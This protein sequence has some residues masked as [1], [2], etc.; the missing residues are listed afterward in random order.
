MTESNTVICKHCGREGHQ[1]RNHWNC[2]QHRSRL[3]HQPE[4]NN[5][6][7]SQKV[8]KFC[9]RIGHVRRSN[10]NCG[11]RIGSSN[12][13]SISASVP[14]PIFS[15]QEQSTEPVEQQQQQPSSATEEP[16]VQVTE[17]TICSHC[18]REGHQRR[19]HWNCGANPQNSNMDDTDDADEGTSTTHNF[20]RQNRI[21]EVTPRQDVGHMDS[22]CSICGAHM[23]ISERKA[24]S[25]LRNPEFQMCC[26]NGKSVLEP[27]KPIPE[28]I[29]NLLRNND[30]A[31]RDF[32]DKIRTYNSALSF[33][34][35]NANLDRSVANS[36]V[37][38]YAYRIHGTVYHLMSNSLT[39]NPNE[40]QQPKFAQIYI[41]DSENELQNRMNVAANSNVSEATMLSLQQMMH[42]VNPFVRYFKTMAEVSA[43]Q[44]Q[45]NGSNGVVDGLSN[46]RM[47]FR[48]ENT[49]DPRRYNRPTASEIGILIVGGSDNGDGS[50]E[51]SNRD[52]VIRLKGGEGE[53]LSRIKEINQFYDPLH[54]VLMFPNGDPGWNCGVRSA[55]NDVDQLNINNHEDP[56]VVSAHRNELKKV[57]I[58]D[59][60]SFRLMIR[61]DPNYGLPKSHFVSVH[62][63][64]KLFHQYIVDMY[65]KME[66]QRLNFLRHNQES[67]RADVYK[68]LADAV[69]M[70]DTNM[71]SIGKKVIL[72]STFI[73]SP[74]FLAQLYQ[75]AMSLVRR[76]GKPDLFI[77][78]TCNPSWPEIERELLVNQKAAD[79]P[80]LCA[81]VFNLK[82]RDLLNDIVKKRVL[83]R[84]IAYVY[85]I[86]FQKR[87]LPHAH[88][89]FILSEDDKPRNQTDYDRIVSAEIPDPVNF[90]LAHDTVTTCMIHGP[91][92]IVNP[93]A[94]CMKNGRCSKRYPKEFHDETTVLEDSEGGYPVYRRRN[95]PDRVIFRNGGT[96]TVDNRFVVPHNLYLC[97]KY[98]AHINV[99]ICTSFNSIKYVY[100]Y[101]YKGNDRAQVFVEGQDDNGDEI[102]SFLDSRYVSASEACWRIFSFPMHKEY[103]PH[104]RLAIHLKDEQRV[105]F[106]G[107]DDPETVIGRPPPET[108]LT[109]WF[110]YNKHASSNGDLDA[111]YM[112]YPDFCEKYTFIKNAEPRHWK[113]RQNGL[114][115]GRI[116]SV[117][118]QEV[119]K[120]HLRLLLYKVPGATCFEDIR[121]VEGQVYPTFLSAARAMGLLSDN[122][123]W[124]SALTEAA[125]SNS[126]SSLRRLFCI[127]LAFCECSDPFELWMSHRDSLAE[128]YLY[129]AKQIAVIQNLPLPT[130]IT[131][132]M[133]GHC[134]LDMNDILAIHNKV[135][136]KEIEGFEEVYPQEDTRST[137][138]GQRLTSIER[139]HADL[140]ANASALPDPSLLPFNDDQRLVFDTIRESI[141]NGIIDPTVPRI[142]FID[143]PGGTGKTFLFNALLD[144]VRRKDEIALS[145]AST[146][147]AALLIKGGR[148]SH[149][150]FKIPLEVGPTSMC[151]ISPRDG[152]ASLLRR[153][154]LIVWDES[155]MTSKSIFETVD[156]TMKDIFKDEDTAF[157]NTPFGGRLFVFGGDF[158]QV[159]PV[160]PRAGRSQIVQEC[161]NRSRIWSKVKVLKLRVN[162]R[163]Q[164]AL[165]RNNSQLATE[166]QQFADYLLKIGEGKVPTLVIPP[167]NMPSDYVRI[168]SSMHIKGDNLLNLIDFVY[169]P[170]VLSDITNNIR[171]LINNSILTPKNSNVALINKLCLEKVASE[172]NIKNY[173]SYDEVCNPDNRLIT[174]V[175]LMNSIEDGS[176]PPHHLILSVGCPIMVLR[177]IDP[178]GGVCN[179]TRLIVRSL[180]RH[181]IEAEITTGSNIGE[182]AYI[183]KIRFNFQSKDGKNPIEFRR[184]QFPVRLA[185]AMTI[186]KAQGQTL[187]S[188]GLYL[189]DHVFS[190]GHLYVALSRVKSPKSIKILID[191]EYSDILKNN[192]HY[193]RNVVFDEVFL[194]SS[195]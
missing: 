93:S 194:T 119:E 90:K 153:A 81:R 138:A 157:G 187:D 66:Q 94:P 84:V 104:Q 134:L 11:Q 113:R 177:N 162:M 145:V 88:M 159:L 163:V 47:V 7:L 31:S 108:T 57:S 130:S 91:C 4:E 99:E 151:D 126:P 80:D 54:Y 16:Q 24:N 178:S 87:G 21:K 33:T 172:N 149:S 96:V 122:R 28:V 156:R 112:L 23:W 48:S 58:M 120:Y 41:F 123:E 50:F 14:I 185:F 193:T 143:G 100:K 62:S 132:E 46:I 158:R 183:P 74:R 131:E 133:F 155:S 19:S 95:M 141:D 26:A 103:P 102:K 17:I 109:A 76:F 137:S 180:H 59:F 179:G 186:N 13:T 188:V 140:N 160:I 166:L 70:D 106:N 171:L 22:I 182:I 148:T 170:A 53:P 136:L 52:I 73:G 37:G 49:P 115:V 175:E 127:M 43:E 77:T 117:S 78:F 190:H 192:Q 18:N 6:N 121:T 168:P 12:P 116:Y 125:T 89:L 15:E 38:A 135:N 56:V 189:P 61:P 71:N 2:G 44:Q 45:G 82:L 8:C 40:N 86:E 32:K 101:I 63:F 10:L 173:Y 25:S 169:P 20:A 184:T 65:A 150:G 75:D 60:Y 111:Q 152:T 35:M 191:P 142:F 181:V 147:A 68:G 72:P 67:L 29:A 3:S 9:H 146:G 167:C 139:M 114:C 51:P 92:G 97:A 36:N 174:P 128:D 176:L 118:P 110:N 165:Q 154:K 39:P 105:Y 55:S 144:Y 64:G 34:S 1:R 42:E 27:L 83:G 98:Q 85:S 164:A 69:R 124:S 195:Q 129:K 5:V 107:A 161:M 79:R 30:V